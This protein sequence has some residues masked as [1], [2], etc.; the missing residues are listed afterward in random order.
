MG[1]ADLAVTPGAKVRVTPEDPPRYAIADLMRLML[2]DVSN[3]HVSNV[4]KRVKK[5]LDLPME[6]YKFARMFFM[7]L[8]FDT[9]LD[10]KNN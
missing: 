2:G 6:R 10:R 1:I 5:H 4:M 9:F 3:S 7:M 8:L